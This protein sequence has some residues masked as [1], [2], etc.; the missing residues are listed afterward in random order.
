MYK[1]LESR[2]F[3]SYLLQSAPE[4]LVCNESSLSREAWESLYNW[5]KNTYNFFGEHPE[6][7]MKIIH[8]DD[9][10]QGWYGKMVPQLKADMLKCFKSMNG[11]LELVWNCILVGNIQDDLLMITDDIKITP[12]NICLLGY[13]GIKVKNGSLQAKD[14]PGMFSAACNLSFYP[15]GFRRFVRCLYNGNS[16]I[17][18]SIYRQFAGD[19]IAF[20]KLISWLR[21]NN[22]KYAVT[23]DDSEMKIFE[24]SKISFTKNI[25]GNETDFSGYDHEH[26]GFIAYFCALKG[27]QSV[28]RL[29]IQRVRD[30]L[31]DFNNLNPVLQ[32]FIIDNHARCNNCGYC[33]QRSK[34]KQKPYTIITY[35]KNYK[36][37]LCP[38]NYVYTYHWG[39][40][41]DKLAECIIAFLKYFE[42]RF[43]D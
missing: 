9:A 12:R 32:K 40:I 1:N 10:H 21:E 34:G 5:T 20:D 33:T 14:Y 17:M 24:S 27:Q 28:F 13:T 41:N 29:L 11:L 19:N 39:K 23:L 36:Y 16:D 6:L 26:I 25:Y 43:C 42:E 8:E 38:I 15:D 18:I 3:N 30:V 4:L 7:I 22:Y 35:Y 37:A 31:A 2:I